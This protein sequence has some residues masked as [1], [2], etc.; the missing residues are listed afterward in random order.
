MIPKLEVKDLSYSYHSMDGETKALS[1]ISF[2][3]SAGEFLAVVGPS[4]CGK[5]T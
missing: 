3:V 2:S 5:S 1:N 4:G